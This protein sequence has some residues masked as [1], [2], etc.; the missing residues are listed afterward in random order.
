MI[1]MK[2]KANTALTLLG[3]Q[4]KMERPME[5]VVPATAGTRMSVVVEL[6]HQLSRLKT[7]TMKKPISAG[8]LRCGVLEVSRVVSIM[9]AT[10]IPPTVDAENQISNVARFL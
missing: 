8:T 2:L 5:L 10:K 7:K 3:T 9:I 4:Q 6:R 1:A